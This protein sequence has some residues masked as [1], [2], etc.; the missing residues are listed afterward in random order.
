M[1]STIVVP[2]SARSLAMCSCRFAALTKVIGL[3]PPRLR[4][5]VD[6]LQA[7]TM[8][9]VFGGGPTVDAAVLTTIAQACRDDERL[10]F[11]YTRRDGADSARLVEPHRLVALGRR[12]Y[13]VAW[14]TERHDWRTFRV[15]R[16]TGAQATG[17]R[18]RPRELPAPDAA[19]FVSA[20]LSS[21]PMRYQVVVRVRTSAANVRRVVAHWATVQVIDD[22]SCLLLMN[23]DTFDWP[24]ALLGWI[25]EP[26]EVVEPPQLRE[27]LRRIGDLLVQGAGRLSE[28]RG[29]QPPHL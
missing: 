28:D 25:G 10:R 9:V 3:L 26:F 23:A 20:Q 27:H 11:D 6:A 18:F 12:W 14:D 16:L 7:Y 22:E 2:C 21:I 29:E 13:L 17:A 24:S 5:R 8:P 4:R 19:A 1:V 15:D